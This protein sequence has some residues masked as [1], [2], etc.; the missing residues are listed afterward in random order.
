MVI[1]EPLIILLVGSINLI[2]S[3]ETNQ[4]I[5]KELRLRCDNYLRAK[6]TINFG[7]TQFI[8]I[9]VRRIFFNIC[10]YWL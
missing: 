4:M 10:G 5:F 3:N 9:S 2:L 1:R 7:I 8:P 6:I